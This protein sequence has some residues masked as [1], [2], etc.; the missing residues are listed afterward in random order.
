MKPWN[1]F[2]CRQQQSSLVVVVVF[3]LV[4]LGRIKDL[5]GHPSSYFV[6]SVTP[7]NPELP[8]PLHFLLQ[9]FVSCSVFWIH[10]AFV[11]FVSSKLFHSFDS[12]FIA[13][14][15]SLGRPLC[16]MFLY[17]INAL[18]RLLPLRNGYSQRTAPFST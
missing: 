10:H 3:F 6:A 15:P 5:P 13:A 17:P 1:L 2:S 18:L 11:L 4:V 12:C 9:V 7:T 16:C 8:D 14:L